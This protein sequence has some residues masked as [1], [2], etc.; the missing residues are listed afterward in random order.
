MANDTVDVVHNPSRNRFEAIV[1]G[2]LCRLEYRLQDGVMI[3]HHTEVPAALGG[4]G[5]GGLMVA[6]AVAYARANALKVKPTCSYA[7]EW[8]NRHSESLDL[9][10]S[11]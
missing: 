5:I 3:I 1:D 8:M 7:R 2:E 6:A 9:L 4:R 11:P 10:A